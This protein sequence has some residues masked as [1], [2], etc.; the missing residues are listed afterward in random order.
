MILYSIN[1]DIPPVITAPWKEI[2]DSNE[3]WI[4]QISLTPI[5][6]LE[7]IIGLS[8]IELI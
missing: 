6:R 8:L 3:D 5:I 2:V 1:L 4:L 7:N